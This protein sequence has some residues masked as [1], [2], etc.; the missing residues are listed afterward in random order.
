MNPR[1]TSNSARAF[2]GRRR[3]CYLSSLFNI[4]AAVRQRAGRLSKSGLLNSRRVAWVNASTYSAGRCGPGLGWG[5]RMILS[6]SSRKNSCEAEG[7]VILGPRLSAS[8]GD[9]LPAI[10]TNESIS[11]SFPSAADLTSTMKRKS[12]IL[13]RYRRSPIARLLASQ[14]SC[15]CLAR[16]TKAAR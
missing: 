9:A 11:A 13:A 15:K 5:P 8:W 7:G 3:D 12:S 6:L 16:R 1:K 4:L 10:L 2:I 14:M